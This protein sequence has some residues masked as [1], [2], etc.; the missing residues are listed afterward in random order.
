MRYVG[1]EEALSREGRVHDRIDSVEGVLAD[2]RAATAR[3]ET[4]VGQ[5]TE[6]VG[7]LGQGLSDVSRSVDRVL[8]TMRVLVG[9]ASVAA[10]VA[11]SLAAWT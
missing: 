2:Q 3:L 6:S 5:L 1:I 11:A 7:A 4:Q 9:L 10:A 8:W